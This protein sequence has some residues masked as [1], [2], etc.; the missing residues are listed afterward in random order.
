MTLGSDSAITAGVT[1]CLLLTARPPPLSAN[2]SSGNIRTRIEQARREMRPLDFRLRAYPPSTR[3]YLAFYGLDIGGTEHFFGSFSSGTFRLAA[4]VFVPRPERPSPADLEDGEAGTVVLVHGYYDHAGVLNHLIRSLLAN[5]HT[6]AV[7]DHPGHGLSSGERAAIDDFAT[8]TSV[9]RDFLAICRNNLDGPIHLVA[10]SMGCAVVTDYLLAPRSPAGTKRGASPPRP[11]LGQIVFL[12]PLY[13]SAA[14]KLSSAGQRLTSPFLTSVPRKFRNNSSD[15]AFRRFVRR[16]PLQT[17][18]V[19]LKWVSALRD[20]N[21]R[22]EGYPA[23]SRPITVIQGTADTTVD[24]KHNLR[25]LR[26]KFP[27]ADIVRIPGG[28]H[29]LV[30]EAQPMRDRVLERVARALARGPEPVRPRAEKQRPHPPNGT[31]P[32]HTNP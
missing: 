21:E 12:A 14:W 29:Q 28:G 23:S 25:F 27:A 26:S 1:L 10:H 30:N 32:S 18:R 19:P 2:P 5:G 17:R 3:A 13:H 31:A 7:Y 20:W 16:D 4:H 8:Y 9:L 15:P 24:W 6:V 11:A 22:A